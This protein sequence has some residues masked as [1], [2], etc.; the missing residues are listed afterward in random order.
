M[1]IIK[2]FVCLLIAISVSGCTLF[3][4]SISLK[5][6]L[7]QQS[8]LPMPQKMGQDVEHIKT[9]FPPLQTIDLKNNVMK[10][11]VAAQNGGGYNCI[12]ITYQDKAFIQDFNLG[13]KVVMAFS[14]VLTRDIPFK[15]MSPFEIVQS[16]FSSD[17]L[18]LSK[19][20]LHDFIDLIA[21]L[22][23][24][25]GTNVQTKLNSHIHDLLDDQLET[26]A[27]KQSTNLDIKISLDAM[28]AAYMKAYLDGTFV[29]RWGVPLSQPD[30][31]KLGS[32]SVEPFTKVALEAFLDYKM[33]TPIVHDPNQSS[34]NK[35]PTFAVIFP[36][37]YEDISAQPNAPG[38]TSAEN[39]AIKYLSGLSGEA[40]KHLS[41]LLVKSL[42]G[43]SFGAKISTG[44]NTTMAQ[45]VST[46]CEELLRRNTEEIGYDILEKFQYY[47]T[48]D[49]RYPLGYAASF[50]QNRTNLFN[51]HFDTNCD[52]LVQQGVVTLLMSQDNLKNLLD[53]GWKLSPSNITNYEALAAGLASGDPIASEIVAKL[54]PAAQEVVKAK[55]TLNSSQQQTLMDALNQLIQSNTSIYKPDNLTT[56][57]VETAA[58]KGKS[59]AKAD[60][61][62][63]NYLLLLDA[64]PSAL[65]G[66]SR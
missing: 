30:L 31:T 45:A 61:A 5:T 20:D 27:I 36:Q 23:S 34:T 28:M 19:D 3:N 63:L 49:A 40:S 41:S 48:N 8:I 51:F 6:A 42:G 39:E 58:L 43:A 17:S 46:I 12:S 47:A 64:F 65:T 2:M 59:P 33:M 57:S 7:M 15:I 18:T 35:T 4:R 60:L 16:V 10:R 22:R 54:S 9:V 32:D 38:I 13:D 52:D 26:F 21:K 25:Q 53:G 11:E 56:P 66:G 50:D 29:D 1:K 37:L 24:F 62:H 55:G 14:N 44:D